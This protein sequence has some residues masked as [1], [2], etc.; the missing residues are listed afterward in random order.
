[1]PKNN[2]SPSWMIRKAARIARE[3]AET[4]SGITGAMKAHVPE[5]KPDLARAISNSIYNAGSI[6]LSGELAAYPSVKDL[7]PREFLETFLLAPSGSSLSQQERLAIIITDYDA[8]TVIVA[9]DTSDDETL[10]EFI[11][12]KWQALASLLTEE[13]AR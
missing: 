8:K 7:V 3:Y 2:Q 6:L 12:L 13:A 4:E 1:M 5:R 9:I 11:M 10:K